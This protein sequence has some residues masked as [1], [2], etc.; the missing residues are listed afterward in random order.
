MARAGRNGGLIHAARQQPLDEIARREGG[1][2]GN[3]DDASQAIGRR[4]GEPDGDARQRSWTRGVGVRQN[5]TIERREARGGAVGVD[6][7]ARDLRREAPDRVGDHGLA[8]KIDEGLVAPHSGGQAAGQNDA[9]DRAHAGTSISALTEAKAH[10]IHGSRAATLDAS[11]VAP[12]HTR[13]PGGAS[14]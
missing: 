5:R 7:E 8:I 6:G 2:A 10:S 3:R 14:L 11:T 13:R 1:V 9:G 12:H 4:E